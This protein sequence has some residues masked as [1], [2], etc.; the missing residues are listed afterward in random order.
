VVSVRQFRPS[1]GER[2]LAEGAATDWRAGPLGAEAGT[3]APSDLRRG[4]APTVPGLQALQRA[5]GNRAVTAHLGSRAAASIQRYTTVDPG[6]KAYPTRWT[7]R[8][9]GPD[10]PARDDAFFTHQEGASGS[11]YAGTAD[12]PMAR[13]VSTASAPLDIADDLDLAISSLGEA[14]SFFAEPRRIEQ[15]NKALHGK[16]FFEGTSRYLR[17]DASHAAGGGPSAGP[18]AGSTRKLFEVRPVVRGKGGKGL[19]VRTPQRCNEMAEFVSGHKFL[20]SEAGKQAWK[21]VA[22]VVQEMTNKDWHT[23]LMAAYAAGKPTE[24]L[25]VLDP[26][27]A[28]FMWLM[29]HK[30]VAARME[31][32]LGRLLANTHLHP[33]LGSAITTFG[34]DTSEGEERSKQEGADLFGYHFATVVAASGGDYVTMENY[35]RR[36]KVVTSTLSG[37]DPLFFFRMYGTRVPEQTWH[38]RQVASGNF[39]GAIVSFQVG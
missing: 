13:L 34:L 2:R 23:P 16:V 4:Q 39:R 33:E 17:L 10:R 29:Q 15:A 31:M 27:L 28:D 7:E 36:D 6:T 38:A 1:S 11:Y 21:L 18:G 35:A 26:M 32:Y 14:K 25:A 30:P 8:R 5:V 20:E 3:C 24:F 12:K 37:G 9:L 19:D 22:S